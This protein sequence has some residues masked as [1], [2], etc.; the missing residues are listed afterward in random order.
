MSKE[1][2]DVMAAFQ[3]IITSRSDIH[4]NTGS[5][6]KEVHPGCV[7]SPPSADADEEMIAAKDV[8]SPHFNF[9][10]PFVSSL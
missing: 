3:S 5:D 6:L 1:V 10:W 8:L 2:P 7:P 4:Y 9:H